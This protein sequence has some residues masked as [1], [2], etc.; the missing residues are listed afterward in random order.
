MVN[1]TGKLAATSPEDGINATVEVN[2]ATGEGQFAN[3][4][5]DKPLTDWTH[6]FEQFNLDP[7]EFEIDGDTVT[8]KAWQQSKGLEDGTR[9]T[10]TLYSYGAKFRRKTFNA[11]VSIDEARRILNGWHPVRLKPATGEPTGFT[12][13]L[14]DLQLGK[15]EAPDNGT[16]ETLQRIEESLDGVIEQIDKLRSYGINL[17][18]LHLANMGDHTEGTH[19]SYANQP[20]SVDMNLRDQ[21]QAALEV[22]LHWIRTL[23][24][25]FENVHYTATICNHGTLS[26]AGGRE[27]VTDDADNATGLI[28]DLLERICKSDTRLRHVRFTIPR[29]EMI[30]TTSVEGVN[31]AMA[32]GQ[33]ITG[34]EASWLAAQSQNLTQRRGF[35]PDLWLTAHKHHAQLT[36]FGPYTRIQATTVDPGSKFFED[37]TGQYSR[38][39][40]TT[41][42]IGEHLPAKWDHLRIV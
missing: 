37:L 10:V 17:R 30:T 28:G 5:S 32:H 11:G 16:P 36:D 3:V 27:N 26:R 38:T 2:T 7:Q 1:Q 40:V 18:T 41:F 20:Y 13:A 8:M 14:A 35:A 6:V 29:D 42:T 33:K 19:G 12:T 24:P 25:L 15:R 22:N 39:G 9:S 31:I 23:A 21:L 4:R 34:S